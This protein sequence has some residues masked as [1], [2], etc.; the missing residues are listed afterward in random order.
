MRGDTIVALCT[1]QGKAALSVLRL[2]GPK[3]LSITRQIADF[4]PK[5]L[6]SHRLYFGLLKYKKQQLDQ[7]LISYF[8]KGKSFTGEESLEISCHGGGIYSDILKVLIELG[9]RPAQRGEFSLQAFS[10][11]K[12]DLIQAEA[13]LQLIEGE[14]TQARR[15]ALFQLQGHLSDRFL[16]LE[17]KWLVLLSHIE[18]DIDFSL[19]NLKSLTEKEIQSQ[20]KNLEKEVQE[21]VFCYKPFEKLQKG[22]SFGIFGLSNVGKS[23]LFN[24]LLKEEKAIVS[25]EEGTTRDIVEAQILN[26][27]GLNIVLKDSAGFRESL[28]LGEKKG[29]QKA[30]QLFQECDYRLLLVDSL[31][32]LI[33][34][35]LFK[36]K[37]ENSWL[38]FTKRDLL[39]QNEA[40]L[41]GQDIKKKLIK[42]LKKKYKNLKFPEKS[43]LISSISGE[44]ISE[45]RESLLSCGILDSEEALI[46]NSRHFKALIKM[47]NS[48]KNCKKIQSERDIIAL[49]LRQGLLALYEILGKHIEDKILDQIFKQFC[50]G[51]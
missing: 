46:S 33:E 13:L 50:I 42:S 51:K 41:S 49:E 43:F 45:L 6:M 17:K 32:V 10:N 20:I 47:R 15:Q 19:E 11:G 38:V 18:A 8:K 16:K 26:P 5:K 39:E 2:S 22:L 23:S 25:Q 40:L 27:K 28:S 4:L 30:F 37:T 44:G 1:A 3:A 29:Q 34:K 7:V 14:N 9:A 48:L 21:L 36:D 24:A 12:M 35:S 31:D